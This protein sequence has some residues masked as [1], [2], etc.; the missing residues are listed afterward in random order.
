VFAIGFLVR[1]FG[2]LVLGRYADRRGRKAALTLSVLLMSGG[3]LLIAL[4]PTRATLG[5]GAALLLVFARIVQGISLGGEYGASAVY[6]AE[7]APRERRGLYGSFQYVT[8]ILG[9][10]LAIAVLLVLQLLVLTPRE[11]EVWGWRIPF[12]IGALCALVAWQLRRHLPETQAF[13]AEG[14]GARAAAGRLRVLA[15]YPREVLIVIGLTLGG[16]VMFY[17]FTTYMPTF[18]VN[19]AGL[20]PRESTVISAITLLGYLLLQPLAG[21]L[22]D[23]IG[24]RPLLIGFGV[25]GTLAT[26]PLLE[27]LAQAHTMLGATLLILTALVILSGYTG[28][29]AIVKAELFPAPIR[30]LGV[31]LPYALSVSLFG[32]TAPMLALRFRQ[33]G[34]ESWFYWYVAACV[35]CSLVVY[36][37]M[38]ESARVSRL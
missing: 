3:S 30:A 9:Q 4:T 5:A 8:L 35:A 10:L 32:G 1:P 14:Q 34:R 18:L 15:R 31:G 17:T 13:I 36:V 29:C 22:S 2:G 23:R 33:I 19:T 12:A 20:A 38:R 37:C 28:V 26:V 7:A 16:T 6:L 24:R 21:S 27:R 11:L 25:L